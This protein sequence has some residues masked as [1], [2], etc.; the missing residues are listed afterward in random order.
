MRLLPAFP[1]PSLE[2]FKYLPRAFD[3]RERR[4]LR[5]V[6]LVTVA[7]F[8]VVTV[9]FFQRHIEVLPKDGGSYTEGMVGSPQ[10]INPVLTY[11]NEIDEDLVKLLFVGLY[12]TGE[13]GGLEHVLAA[14]EE[15]SEDGK[16]YLITLRQGARWHDGFPITTADVQFTF[17]RIMDPTVQSPLRK[18]FE[19]IEAIEP[20][21]DTTLKIVLKKPFAPFLASLTFG[22]LPQHIW[23]DVPAA[24]FR[25]AEYNLKPIGSGPFAFASY[26]KTRLGIIQ[27]YRLER[28]DDYFLER[29]HLNAITFRFY[30]SKETLLEA[31][32]RDAIEGV[33][34]VPSDLRAAI[35]KEGRTLYSLRLPQY[36]AV[37]FNQR[38]AL[39]KDKTV[40]Q[41]LERAIEKTAILRDAMNGAGEVIHTP[42]LPGFLG[43]NPEV[44]GLAYNADEARKALDAAG[45]TLQEGES[46]RT[47]DGKELRFSL[48]T[49]D[50]AEYIKTAELLKQFWNA[51]GVAL[52][53]RLYSGDDIVKKVIQ[54]RNYEAL[55]FGEIVGADPDPYPFWHSSQSFDPGL[56]LAIFYNKNVD[57]LLEEARSTRDEEQRR[58]KYLHFQNILAEEQPAIFLVNPFYTYA[59]DRK[60]RG[61][62]LERIFVPSDR[63]ANVTAWYEKTQWGWK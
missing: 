9:R 48:S 57:Q 39:L 22:I 29:P 58:M 28:F 11:A 10:Y 34:F 53:I 55:L 19:N 56:N 46:V 18:Q 50:R 14:H 12:Q 47:K 20:M 7:S 33:H 59:L 2:Q 8:A 54:S 1:W 38:T 37:F 6:A 49:V 52:E 63:F 32:K 16:T 62:G 35:E 51:V 23:G 21:S 40:R 44:R 24:S 3:E 45:W 42:I 26:T 13:D 43:H 41:T 30:E 60:I 15:T 17:D 31:V 4:V 36:T 27:S 25:L 61:F 5:I